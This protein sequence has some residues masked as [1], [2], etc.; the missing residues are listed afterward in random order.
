MVSIAILE[1]DPAQ[2]ASLV[3]QVGSVM[4]SHG[5]ACAVRGY[6]ESEPLLREASGSDVFLLDIQL[7]EAGQ[8]GMDVARSIRASGGHG[9]ILFVTASVAY[10][11]EGY[12]VRAFDYLVKPVDPKK[13]EQKLLQAVRSV[14]GPRKTFVTI[15]SNAPA[16]VCA[17]D[18]AFIDTLR[19]K[20]TVHMVSGDVHETYESLSSI[21][22][23]LPDGSFFRC[24]AAYLV[25]VAH[26]TA[27]LPDRVCVGEQS[28]PLARNRKKP[29][30][31]FL[32][33]YV[34]SEP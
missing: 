17:Q 2:L 19:R 10:A 11:V 23:R 6:S 22:G 27:V 28:V 13:L 9:A 25:N 5:V 31:D 3:A 20:T 32:A 33:A 34:G 18:I 12:A 30:L 16:L 14:Q 7:G 21:Q 4:D 8:D 26:V 29:F 1:D 15:R 24:H